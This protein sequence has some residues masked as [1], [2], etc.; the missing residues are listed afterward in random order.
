MPDDKGLNR[1]GAGGQEGELGDGRWREPPK[2]EL[3]RD[4]QKQQGGI[5][6]EPALN[7]DSQRPEKHISD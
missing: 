7:P 2:S 5:A 4:Q 1:G 6:R 3:E